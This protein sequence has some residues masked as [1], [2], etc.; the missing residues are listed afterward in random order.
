MNNYFF[1]L[2]SQN[3]TCN[4]IKRSSNIITIS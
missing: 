2:F 3:K 1:K 4:C